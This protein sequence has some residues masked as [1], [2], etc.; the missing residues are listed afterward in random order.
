MPVTV[1]VTVP[2]TVSKSAA[3]ICRDGVPNA[4]RQIAESAPVA[5]NPLHKAALSPSFELLELG[6]H[7][8]EPE[9]TEPLRSSEGVS[10]LKAPP[11]FGGF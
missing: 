1:P 5:G 6:D 2:E 3:L 11:P 8:P 10:A 4:I 9:P 7:I